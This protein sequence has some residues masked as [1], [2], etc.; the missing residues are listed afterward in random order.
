MVELT[1]F[2]QLRPAQTI[3]TEETQQIGLLLYPDAALSDLATSLRDADSGSAHAALLKRYAGANKTNEI[4]DSKSLNPVVL[5]LYDWLNFK[6]RPLKLEDFKAFILIPTSLRCPPVF[7]GAQRWAGEARWA[8][9]NPRY[10]YGGWSVGLSIFDVAP[11][12]YWCM[13]ASAGREPLDGSAF[14]FRNRRGTRLKVLVVDAQGV[15]LAQRPLH[16]GRFVLPS[17]RE[18]LWSLN[19]EQF[20]WLCAGVDSQR[21]SC[22]IVHW[23]SKFNSHNEGMDEA[24]LNAITDTDAL[25][26]LVREQMAK[27]AQRDI[28][29]ARRDHEI[30]YKT[31][32]I[33]KLTHE[34]A[35]L[36]RVQSRPS[37]SA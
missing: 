18:S 36:R 11:I 24:A 8:V 9:S 27:V 16:R 5:A 25:R 22:D 28:I 3:S 23:A 15:W 4:T 17:T 26:V 13:Y 35:R 30:A 2:Q 7:S 31:A 34:L 12:D 1:R 21:L 32:K 6:A 14:V 20:R 37:P 19:R 33:D 10:G 29:I